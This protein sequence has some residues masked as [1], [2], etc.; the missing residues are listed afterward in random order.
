MGVVKGEGIEVEL[1]YM[2]FDQARNTRVYKF[3]CKG[4]DKSTVR[5]VVSAD[6][7]LFLQ[8]HIG[9][10]EGPALCAQK[11]TSDV[12]AHEKR[13]H[14]LTN[15]DLLA[16][17]AVRTAAELRKASVRRPGPKRRKPEP[18]SQVIL[19]GRQG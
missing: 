3:D 5:H 7:V 4:P 2:G 10:Q 1:R 6:M 19:G 13:D 16:Y 18:A 17:V 14:V 15:D 12:E 8:H 11:L 9:I